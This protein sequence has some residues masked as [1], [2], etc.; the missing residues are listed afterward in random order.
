MLARHLDNS[1]S[2]GIDFRY[3]PEADVDWVL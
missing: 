1:I 2:K 3:C